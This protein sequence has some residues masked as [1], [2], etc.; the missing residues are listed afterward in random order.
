MLLSNIIMESIKIKEMRKY[1][2]E[3][4][5][6]TKQIRKQ[7]KEMI[8]KPEIKKELYNE[9]KLKCRK[10]NKYCKY[11]DRNYTMETY[12]L[13]RRMVKHLK[14]KELYYAKKN[15]QKQDTE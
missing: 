15:S 4:E 14:N 9:T 5:K 1:V 8:E 11:C 2:K 12:Y 13:H 3:L 7:I 10:K 6:T